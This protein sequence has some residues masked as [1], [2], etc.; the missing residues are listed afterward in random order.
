MVDLYDYAD[1]DDPFE[2]PPRLRKSRPVPHPYKN[3]NIGTLVVVRNRG[4]GETLGYWTSRTT[5]DNL[6]HKFDSYPI[7]V[8]VLQNLDFHGVEFVFVYERDTKTL[9]EFK[10]STYDATETPSYDWT[11]TDR[12]G[13]EIR[14][15]TQKCPARDDAARTWD[16]SQYSKRDIWV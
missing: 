3:H 11:Q 1:E 14:T 5:S 7:T 6:F 13:N 8:Q 12:E 9:Y 4:G 2:N 15:D 16:L 10:F